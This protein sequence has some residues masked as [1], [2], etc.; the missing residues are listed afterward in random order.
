MNINLTK[1]F[2]IF[3]STEEKGLLND[4]AKDFEIYPDLRKIDI[5]IYEAI[6]DENQ[7]QFDDFLKFKYVFG[8]FNERKNSPLNAYRDR[9]ITINHIPG[10]EIYHFTSLNRL[11]KK[12]RHQVNDAYIIDE[13]RKGEVTETELDFKKSGDFI[14]QYIKLYIEEFPELE[15]CAHINHRGV[16]DIDN[17]ISPIIGFI[18]GVSYDNL[19]YT[20][21]YRRDEDPVKLLKRF[22]LIDREVIEKEL[23]DRDVALY[24]PIWKKK[25]RDLLSIEHEL[26]DLLKP[27]NKHCNSM[28]GA[29]KYSLEHG[30]NE[31]KLTY[32]VSN[33]ELFKRELENIIFPDQFELHKYSISTWG[34]LK[35]KYI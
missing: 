13:Y 25:S 12:P 4:I 16:Y 26:V 7:L 9:K 30:E 20:Y 3:S 11:L 14:R 23:K 31:I 34:T 33:Q 27:L 17:G 19:D 1:V 2:N 15:T 18:K 6:D 29:Q 10:H 24:Q 28:F 8:E 22:K 21:P 32:M 35:V 5:T